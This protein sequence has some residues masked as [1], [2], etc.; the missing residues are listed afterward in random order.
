MP[1]RNGPRFQGRTST[2][3]V[4]SSSRISRSPSVSSGNHVA[5]TAH[6]RSQ[7]SRRQRVAFK[8]L[9]SHRASTPLAR[10]DLPVQSPIQ[11]HIPGAEEG[12]GENADED[13][14]NEVVMAVDI[15]NKGTV[16]CS[17]YVAREEKLYFME[18]MKLGGIDIVESLRLSIDP[19]VILISGRADDA[20]ADKLD[21]KYNEAA[22]VEND[23]DV[24]RMPYALDIRPSSEFG[25]ESAKS[26]LLGLKIGCF[27][28]PHVSFIVPGDVVRDDSLELEDSDGYSGRPGLLLQLAGWIDLNSQITVGCAGAVLAYLQ[29]RRTNSFL[30]GDIE[31]A[32]FF[33]VSEIAMFTLN[34]TMFINA[35]TLL[36]LQIMQSESNPH[37][38]NQ[39][40]TKATSGAKEGLSVYGL[41]RHLARTPQGKQLLRQQFLR[42]SLSLEIIHER[43]HSIS[44]FLSPENSAH[45]QSL[46]AHL[47]QVQNIRVTL[48]KLRKGISGGSNKRVSRTVWSTLRD[49]AYNSLK[50]VDFICEIAGGEELRIVALIRA[51]FDQAKFQFIGKRIQAV[52]NFEDSVAHHRTI[53]NPGVDDVLDEL[54]RQ[55]DG[56]PDLLALVDRT[57]MQQ[58]LVELQ[59]PLRV[60]YLPRI[61]FVIEVFAGETGISDGIYGSDPSNRWT[62]AFTNG[63]LA[64]Y[65]S[66][67][68]QEM[69]EKFGDIATNIAD[70]EIEIVHALAQEILELEDMLIRCSDI[71]GQLDVLL[72]LSQGAAQYN[73]VRPT[74]DESNIIKIKGGRHILQELVVDSFVANDTYIAGGG[75]KEYVDGDVEDHSTTEAEDDRGPNM[76]MMT[77]PNYSGKSVYLKQ[78]AIIVYMAHIGSFV[79]ASSAVIGLTDLVLTRISTRETVSKRQSVFMIDLQQI[80]LMISLCTRQSLLIIDEFGKGTESADGAG[81]AAGVLEYFLSLEHEAP[82]VIAS[83]HFHEIFENGFLNPGPSLAFAFMELRIDD[84]AD[85]PSE[86]VTYLYNLREGRTMSSLGTMC[87]RLN[88]VP[89]EVVQRAEELILL[90]SR[91]E[92]LVAACTQISGRDVRDLEMAEEVTRHA[93]VIEWGE[94]EDARK[95]LD[96]IL[97]QADAFARSVSQ[98]VGDSQDML[99]R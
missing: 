24:F 76:L 22:T 31:A 18:D 38:H 59:E 1:S 63:P 20:L 96:D 52:V 4:P 60:H 58:V 80:S 5:A 12:E 8:S 86:Q 73:L 11:D 37:F 41:F 29:K 42:P 39:G 69:D 21:T 75:G 10:S 50:M 3:S 49:F 88:G 43:Q 74:V 23:N 30:P 14:L 15:R 65:K 87:A 46:V 40:P 44:V 16:G 70:K 92:D 53:V 72:A 27:D 84:E 62:L 67:E 9:K 35:D 33:R 94:V 54:R 56:L 45:V 78:V 95:V 13:S 90:E 85:E 83:T 6:A 25:Y 82:K 32:A 47:K 77:G 57:L 97:G 66:A 93:L 81:L 19:T 36:S 71:C 51:N 2:L 89:E 48:V 99:M 7:P 61:G 91:G 98:V 17:Y 55:Y 79:P 34:D 64:Y 26:K 28:G 68:M